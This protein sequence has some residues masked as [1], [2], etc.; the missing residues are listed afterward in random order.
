MERKLIA[1]HLV[2]DNEV[3][4]SPKTWDSPFTKSMVAGVSTST[5]KAMLQLLCEYVEVHK[6]VGM[7]SK[8]VEYYNKVIKWKN[9]ATTT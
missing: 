8:M 3:W 2:P 4:V 5:N 9:S 6:N 1:N 7:S